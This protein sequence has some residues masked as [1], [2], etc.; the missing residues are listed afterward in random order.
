MLIES[1]SMACAH[2]VKLVRDFSV[3]VKPWQP[4]IRY[5]TKPDE[6]HDLTLVSRR[7]YGIPDEFLTVMAAAGLSSVETPM[8]ER[9]LVLPTPQK[10]RELK[11]LA[12]FDNLPVSRGFHGQHR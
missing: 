6:R 8:S 1:N 11:N 9:V 3:R 12:Q 5:Q 10:L 4:A 2:F 7:V